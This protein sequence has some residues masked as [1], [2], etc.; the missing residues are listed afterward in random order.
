MKD[1]EIVK[2]MRRSTYEPLLCMKN[3]EKKIMSIPNESYQPINM[4]KYINC[5]N[6][7]W[8]CYAALFLNLIAR[9]NSIPDR[10]QKPEYRN[11]IANRILGGKESLPRKFYFLYIY[12][13]S[14]Y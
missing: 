6:L 9:L 3:N 7:R 4:A 13:S 5:I 11:R 14:K 2:T 10:F 12:L 1:M 8:L